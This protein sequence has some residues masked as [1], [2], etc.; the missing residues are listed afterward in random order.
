M[1][2]HELCVRDACFI[3][4]NLRAADLQEIA[5]QWQ[6]FDARTLGLCAVQYSIPGF[7]WSI[8]DG[9][10]Q[11]V[12]AYGFSQATPF[13]PEH[14]QAWAFGTDQFR[15]AVPLMTRHLLSV[16]DVIRERCRRCQVITLVGHDLSH[17]WLRKLGARREGL[18]QSYGRN[19]EAFEVYAWTRSD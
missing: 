8:R 12:A 9:E 17:R 7:A 11:P 13:D 14:W 19:G 10:G 3:A 16:A 18:L 5:P 1:V 2:V 6:A 15:R 4:A